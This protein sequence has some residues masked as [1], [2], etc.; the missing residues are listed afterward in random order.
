[1]EK[2]NAQIDEYNYYKSEGVSEKKIQSYYRILEENGRNYLYLEKYSSGL[3]GK[4]EVL[5][6]SVRY[7]LP[8]VG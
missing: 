2:M 4:E 5:L 6:F 7:P 1:M 3:F 8:N